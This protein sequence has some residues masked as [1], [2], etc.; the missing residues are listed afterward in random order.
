MLLHTISKLYDSPGSAREF[1]EDTLW[2][3]EEAVLLYLDEKWRQKFGGSESIVREVL[4]DRTKVYET[5]SSI[6]DASGGQIEQDIC[7]RVS[8]LGPADLERWRLN[9]C[10]GLREMLGEDGLQ[11]DQVLLDVPGRRLEKVGSVFITTEAGEVKHIQEMG[12]PVSQL[13]PSLGLLAKRLRVFVHPD[14]MSRVRGL[15]AVNH[16]ELV[17][18][19]SDSL[20]KTTNQ[21][22]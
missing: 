3:T 16:M 21:A 6:Q 14:V 15:R 22:V 5:L 20:P 10:A 17:K 4:K 7:Y 19:V 1:V 12:G 18:L 2:M 13:A 11:D 9:L 8:R